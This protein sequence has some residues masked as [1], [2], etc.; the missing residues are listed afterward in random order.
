MI[1]EELTFVRLIEEEKVNKAIKILEKP[2][3]GGI[4][5]LSDETIEILQQK[6]SEASEA[7]DEI[8]LKETHQEVHPVTYESINS[9]MVKDAIKRTRGAAGPSGM[10]TDG[11]RLIL[12]SGNFGN[13]AEDL[14][15]SIAEMTKRLKLLML[16][17]H[18]DKNT[19]FLTLC[20]QLIASATSCPR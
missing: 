5:P 8:L 19:N 3:K 7:S 14:R 17:L 4:L 18:L 13:V 10:D 2:N 20:E 11:W 16:H 1:Q 15:K 12:I 6:H 9:E